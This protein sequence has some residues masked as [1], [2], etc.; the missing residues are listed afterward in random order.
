MSN[1]KCDI[2]AL[3]VIRGL[4]HTANSRRLKRALSSRCIAGRAPLTL[5]SSNPFR[6][7][8]SYACAAG[9]AERPLEAGATQRFQTP[10]CRTKCLRAAN[11]GFIPVLQWLAAA[12]KAM[13]YDSVY[14]EKTREAMGAEGQVD[15][16]ALC[17]R[18]DKFF[19]RDSRVVSFNAKAMTLEEQLPKCDACTATHCIQAHLITRISKEQYSS[20]RFGRYALNQ[21]LRGCNVGLVATLAFKQGESSTK[22]FLSRLS[23][24]FPLSPP[25][26]TKSFSCVTHATNCP[27]SFCSRPA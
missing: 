2:I 14:A 19:L 6:Q 26:A 16:C 17:W 23:Q 13:G 1:A 12:L 5:K 4:P 3:Q 21:L 25:F 7:R 27:A 15:G 11:R 8:A 18:S 20:C 9:G 22:Q 10:S 24:F